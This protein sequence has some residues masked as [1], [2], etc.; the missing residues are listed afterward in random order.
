M[1]KALKT[2]AFAAS[3]VACAAA[4]LTSAE[5]TL[6]APGADSDLEDALRG[7]SLTLSA[8][9]E[10]VTDSQELLA[11]A[12]ADYRRLVAAL[13][14]EG[15]FSGAV[16]IRVDGREASGLS[17]LNE[18]AAIQ[19]IDIAVDTGPSFTFSQA[20]VA[21][22]P[23]EA[24][25]PEGFA[26]GQPAGTVI[27]REAVEAVA[28]GE[29]RWFVPIPKKPETLSP[30][31]GREHEVLVLMARGLD[32]TDIGERL[33]IAENTVRNHLA[34]VYSKLDVSS[35]REA[36]AWAWENGIVKAA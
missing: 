23:P 8:Q 14:E 18:P 27:M 25:L 24:D 7:A 26:P 21:P 36:V 12:K 32:N 13:Y 19:R 33:R 28:R 22:L 15:Y 30:L 34:A 16:S 1:P 17:L 10:D 3:L 5:I 9:D 29:G 2:L 31:T 35:A 6:S 20:E 4:P 11:A